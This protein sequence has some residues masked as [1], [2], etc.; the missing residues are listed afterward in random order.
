MNSSKRF[1]L[2][3][4]RSIF[5]TKRSSKSDEKPLQAR[6]TQLNFFLLK[7]SLNHIQTGNSKK[8]LSLFTTK[9][10][11]SKNKH[12]AALI[13]QAEKVCSKQDIELFSYKEFFYRNQM[14]LRLLFSGNLESTLKRGKRPLLSFNK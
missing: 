5:T 4:V 9:I 13:K 7:A 1:T 12:F 11:N 8:P 10:L 14:S 2:E 6:A 3:K